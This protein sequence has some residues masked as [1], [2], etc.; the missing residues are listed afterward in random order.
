MTW[1]KDTKYTAIFMNAMAMTVKIEFTVTGFRVT[2]NSETGDTQQ[3]M[4][5][6]ERGK[7]KVIEPRFEWPD[8][9]IFEGWDVGVI[10]DWEHAEKH[11]GVW[12]GNACINLVGHP[13]HLRF[14]IDANNLN[15]GVDRGK[16]LVFSPDRSI[17]AEDG[18]ELLFPEEYH[19]GS[20]VIDR[21][22]AKAQKQ[23]AAPL[24]PIEEELAALNREAEELKR[25]LDQADAG[26]ALCA[27]APPTE[28]TPPDSGSL[29]QFAENPEHNGLEL[30]FPGPIKGKVRDLLLEGSPR[31]RYHAAKQLWYTKDTE[32]ARESLTRIVAM[33]DANPDAYLIKPREPK[34]AAATT[35]LNPLI[36]I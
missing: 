12:N 28:L 16:I 1:N 13:E 36:L 20:A 30:K 10:T 35:N 22:I 11:G 29:L 15:E 5:C 26:R 8:T 7:R 2:H 18:G 23:L 31:W 32:A 4:Q 34:P 9:L 19:G 3:R 24:D 27:A 21:V 14:F 6:K 33:F 25:L 17:S